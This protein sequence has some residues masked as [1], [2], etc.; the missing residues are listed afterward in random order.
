[1]E[2]TVQEITEKVFDNYYQD[3]EKGKDLFRIDVEDLFSKYD[4]LIE[5]L[6]TENENLYTDVENLEEQLE[7]NQ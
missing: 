4:R 6:N 1:M 5:R 2:R 3:H 7:M